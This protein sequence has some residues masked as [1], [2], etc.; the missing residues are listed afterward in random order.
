ML[1]RVGSVTFSKLPEPHGG[2]IGFAAGQQHV[3]GGRDARLEVVRD[4][5]VVARRQGLETVVPPRDKGR[6]LG[7]RFVDVLSRKPGVRIVPSLLVET[8]AKGTEVAHAAV[9]VGGGVQEGESSHVPTEHVGD[10]VVE[11]LVDVVLSGRG[12]GN[13]GVKSV[14]HVLAAEHDHDEHD[15]AELWRAPH[16]LAR[17]GNTIGRGSDAHATHLARHFLGAGPTPQAHRTPSAEHGHGRCGVEDETRSGPRH[18]DGQKDPRG[19]E[20]VLVA[21]LPGASPEGDDAH[22]QRQNEHDRAEG[23]KEHPTVRRVGFCNRTENLGLGEVACTGE[24][25]VE[26]VG[27]LEELKQPNDGHKGHSSAGEGTQNEQPGLVAESGRHI[28][29]GHG[30]SEHE[31]QGLQARAAEDQVHARVG[32]E[33]HGQEQRRAQHG[34][35]QH[36]ERGAVLVAEHVGRDD[37][38]VAHEEDRRRDHETLPTEGDH[39]EGDTGQ[40]RVDHGEAAVGGHV[41]KG[42]EHGGRAGVGGPREAFVTARGHGSKEPHEAERHEEHHE[43]VVVRV[44]PRRAGNVTGHHGD[45]PCGDD[46]SGL[47][48]MVACDGRDRE[49]RQRAK[50]GGNGDHR[51]PDG[52]LRGGEEGLQHHGEQGDGPHKQRRTRVDAA[53]RIEPV[54]VKDEVRVLHHDVVDD[55]LHVPRVRTA[56]EVP[57]AGPVAVHGGD[58]VPLGADREG[59]EEGRGD[60]DLRP[61]G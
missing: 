50:D 48:D 5:G 22:A 55:A 27:L 12:T 15:R 42:A 10:D 46:R 47:A 38:D 53:Q 17:R 33:R 2:Q 7:V 19:H 51:P 36:V 14:G 43:G 25:D 52:V 60:H 23:S 39:A 58:D 3:P 11:R 59:H 41:S 34:Q 29:D 20:D 44:G 9:V 57:I 35:H 18:E 4:G 49:D 6:L 56:G 24:Q 40:G 54:C 32:I 28:G 1:G 8:A 61:V 13:A 21:A 26:R 30:E 31:Q 45:E 16:G 37:V